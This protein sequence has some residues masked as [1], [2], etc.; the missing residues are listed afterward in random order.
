MSTKR[1]RV[2]K[3]NH[4][5]VEIEGQKLNNAAKSFLAYHLESCGIKPFNEFGYKHYI[6][7]VSKDGEVWY[8]GRNGA[9][10]TPRSKT[11]FK[12]K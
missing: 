7:K 2:K 8:I 9:Y 1:S 5:V 12:Q 10:R 4:L 6:V 3:E 11:K